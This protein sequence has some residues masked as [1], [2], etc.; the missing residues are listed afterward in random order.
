MVSNRSTIIVNAWK[1]VD[2]NLLCSYKRTINNT[3]IIY[4]LVVKELNLVTIFAQ[5]HGTQ[6][7]KNLPIGEEFKVD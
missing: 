3:Y 5:M 6:N 2:T 7:Q 4:V 1:T